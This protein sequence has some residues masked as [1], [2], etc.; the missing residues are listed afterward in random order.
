MNK[1]GVTCW[2][3]GILL[4]SHF[5]LLGEAVHFINHEP[6]KPKNIILMI[7]DGMG[8]TQV[9]LMYYRTHHGEGFYLDSFP[10][11]GFQKTHSGSNITTDSGAAAT[12][13]A[14]GNKTYNSA[15]GVNL[16]TIPV[17]NILELCR[18][19]DLNT[20]IVVTSSLTDATPAS[21]AAHQPFRGFKEQ[22]ALDYLKQDISFIVGGG[23]N[24]FRDRYLDDRDLL[25]EMKEKGY[26]VSIMD[27]KNFSRK[28]KPENNKYLFLMS[29][30]EPDKAI[31]GR[32]YFPEAIRTACN[33][34]SEQNKGFFLM[35]EASQI[36]YACHQNGEAY[37]VTELTDFNMAIKNAYEFA[38]TNK[39]TLVIVTADHECSNLIIDSSKSMTKPKFTFLSNKHTPQMI[40]VFAFGPGSELFNGIF[41]NTEIFD[42]LTTLLELN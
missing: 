7:G 1:W 25:D 29:E 6:V 27:G 40:P 2:T 16:D 42:K 35:S 3:L 36:D 34:L 41:D 10:V 38:K 15:V 12:A 19:N 30:K 5:Y 8:T 31:N 20:G 9:A 14:T 21:F 33:F 26:V 22:I 37:L 32:D 23:A 39:E 11:V 24:F 28:I 18:S 4:V 13:M 17:I